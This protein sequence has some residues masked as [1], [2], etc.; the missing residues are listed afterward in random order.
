EG[1]AAGL[2]A[3]VSDLGNQGLTVRRHGCGLSLPAGDVEAWAG[4]I[5]RAAGEPQTLAAWREAL[6][7][8]TRVE[9]EGFVYGQLYRAVVAAPA[10]EP[11]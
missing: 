10:A 8:P 2:P 1:F 5:T 6:P 3:L 7:L 11:A 4:A 9:E